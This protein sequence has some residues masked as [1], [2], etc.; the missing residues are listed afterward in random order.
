MSKFNK[1]LKQGNLGE[2]IIAKWLEK[3]KGFK[4]IKYGN[5][6]DYDIVMEA[7]NGK[8]I[9]YEVKTDR[10]EFFKGYKTGNIF[11]ETRCNGKPSGIWGS[12]ADVYVFFFP[13]F[14]E[15]YFIK[16]SDLKDLIKRPDV[17]NRK[18][19][20]GDR[21]AVSGFVIDRYKWKEL[22]SSYKINKLKCWET[23][24]N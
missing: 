17:C 11:V 5:T 21:G 14:E 6:M 23:D 8:Q 1:D 4:L 22:F 2:T 9:T 19:M 7:P 12:I 18:T 3:Y 10:Y 24:K 15:V 20:S 16:T 13:D